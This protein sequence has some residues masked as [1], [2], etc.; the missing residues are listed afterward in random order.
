MLPL[1]PWDI[2]PKP[3]LKS[4]SELTAGQ[5]LIIISKSLLKCRVPAK[6]TCWGNLPGGLSYVWIFVLKVDFMV[7]NPTTFAI[8]EWSQSPYLPKRRADAYELLAC[9]VCSA[10]YNW[11]TLGSDK[12]NCNCVSVLLVAPISSASQSLV[13]DNHLPFSVGWTCWLA[14]INRMQQRGSSGVLGLRA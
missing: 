8:V 13:L 3:P 14:V 11:P 1:N 2:T 6:N 9:H 7:A 5:G 4:R 10:A 12:Y